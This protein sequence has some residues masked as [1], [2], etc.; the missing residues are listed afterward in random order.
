MNIPRKHKRKNILRR[1]TFGGLILWSVWVLTGCCQKEIEY[2]LE[3]IVV[4]M[5]FDWQNAIDANPEGMTMLFF[6][7]E[8]PSQPWRFDISGRAGGNIE[9]LPGRYNVLTFNNDLPGVEFTYKDSFDRFSA[10]TRSVGDTLSAPTG[11]LY[12]A[13][14]PEVEIRNTNGKL[15]ILTLSPDSL[16]TVYH[17]RLDSVSGTERIKTARAVLQG[18]ARSVCLHLKCNSKEYCNVVA[19]LQISGSDHSVLETVTTGFGNPDI[20]EPRIRLDVIVTTSHGSYKKTFD[21][22]DQVMNSK[23]LRNVNINIKGLEI[24]AAD[25][26]EHPDGDDVGITVG[27]DGWQVIEIVYS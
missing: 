23:Y 1:I 21:V 8:G 9:I 24:P 22:T 10:M 16:S 6:P 27:V 17:I 12:S 19:P 2:D 4:G 15:R 20:A 3:P 7:L 11:V 5:N 26:P 13:V 18:L 14:I 25:T